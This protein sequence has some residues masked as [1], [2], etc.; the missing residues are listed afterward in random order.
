MKR[1]FERRKKVKFDLLGKT[2]KRREKVV[3]GRD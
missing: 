3:R 1:E 2:K